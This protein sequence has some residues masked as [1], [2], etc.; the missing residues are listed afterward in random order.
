MRGASAGLTSIL[1]VYWRL[2]LLDFLRR[3]WLRCPFIRTNLPVAVTRNRARAPLC[4]LSLGNFFLLFGLRGVP[5]RDVRHKRHRE[6]TPLERGRPL[7][8]RLVHQVVG[9][10]S[11]QFHA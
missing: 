11:Q 3:R 1:P 7:Q 5:L 9:D 6:E 10:G 2:T 4:V 8:Q